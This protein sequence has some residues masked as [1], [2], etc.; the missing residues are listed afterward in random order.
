MASINDIKDAVLFNKQAYD[1]MNENEKK[2]FDYFNDNNEQ[3]KGGCFRKNKDPE[4]TDDRYDDLVMEKLNTYANKAKALQRIGMDESQVNEIE[5]IR[6]YG[7]ERKSAA[8]GD[9]YFDKVCDDGRWRSS[10]CSITWLFFSNDQ[11]CMYSGRF[12]MLSDSKIELTD[13]YFYKDITNFTTVTE[14]EQT[15][16]YS[17]GKTGCLKKSAEP[18][19][20]LTDYDTFMLI[21]PGDKFRCSVSGVANAKQVIDGV[22]Q[23][24]RE[25]K[26]F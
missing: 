7:F 14:T 5:P 6:L 18:A 22:K 1:Q 23:K 2:V 26:V 15:I 19:K 12:D 9:V 8:V 3:P 4:F 21:V 17:G 16:I 25:K 24:L 11:I 20:K 10:V 13:E